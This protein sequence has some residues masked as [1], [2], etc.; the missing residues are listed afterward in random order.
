M[1]IFGEVIFEQSAGNPDAYGREE[2]I[3]KARALWISSPSGARFGPGLS[4]PMI[5]FCF[6][7]K[8][9][10]F[11]KRISERGWGGMMMMMMMIFIHTPSIQIPARQIGFGFEC[12]TQRR[13][14]VVLMHFF[15]LSA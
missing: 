1:L 2:A 15:S 8:K 11:S 6:K 10:D 5:R 9:F 4:A 3:D 7:A 14:L 13:N 12:F